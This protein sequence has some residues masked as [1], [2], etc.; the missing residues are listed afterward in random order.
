MVFKFLPLINLFF[1][2]DVAVCSDMPKSLAQSI[3]SWGREHIADSDVYTEESQ[4]GR[5]NDIHVT[6]KYGLHTSDTKKVKKIV[7]GFGPFAITF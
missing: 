5:E 4:Y 2:N 6:V 1:L 7:D 3:S